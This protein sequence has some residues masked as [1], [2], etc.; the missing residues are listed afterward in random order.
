MNTAAERLPEFR[1][2]VGHQIGRTDW[3]DLTQLQVDMFSVLTDDWDY[4]HNDPEWAADSAW[5]GTI[6]HGLFVL[7]LIPSV[8]KRLTDLPFVND[9]PAL[10]HTVNYGFDKVRF[11][12]PARLDRPTCATVDLQAMEDKPNG[13]VLMRFA[14]T[15]LQRDGDDEIVSVY[16]DYLLYMDYSE[17]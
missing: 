3:F 2:K 17:A 7:S 1:A 8:M 5:G 11:I 10:G 13:S 16:A 12:N 9:D 4:M 6:A 15:F 14:V